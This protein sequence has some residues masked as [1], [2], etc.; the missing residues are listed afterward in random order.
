MPN[1]GS[2][3][4]ETLVGALTALGHSQQTARQAVAR[5]TR[6][7]WL[8]SERAGRRTRMRVTPRRHNCSRKGA[9]RSSASARP[10]RGTA[11]GSSSSCGCRRGNGSS[12]TMCERGSAA[13]AWLTRRRRADRPPHRAGAVGRGGAAHPRPR[14]R[15][16]FVSR[17]AGGIGDPQELVG[18]WRLDTLAGQYEEFVQP[19]P[20]APAPRGQ[21][22]LPCSTELVHAW[23]KLAFLDPDSPDRA[24]A[25][26][27]AATP[28]VRALPS[29]AHELERRGPAAL[30]GARRGSGALTGALQSQPGESRQHRSSDPCASRMRSVILP[31]ASA[32]S[33]HAI[34]R[35]MCAAVSS[36]ASARS[37]AM[38][39][40]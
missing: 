34:V 17:R 18:A 13:P 14:C 37:R 5:S 10:R 35:P 15:R 20:A 27:M 3:W 21:D 32:P 25:E 1:G 19:V 2:A 23:R 9:C 4:Q 33:V 39:A 30:R 22:G 36:R 40:R 11:G 38:Q 16:A 28:R 31:S 26:R 29:T 8:V 24:P 7:G 12:A 6:D